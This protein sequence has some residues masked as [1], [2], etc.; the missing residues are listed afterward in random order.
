MDYSSLKEWAS[1]R[2]LEIL[3][4]LI[5]TKTKAQ[6]AKN[7]KLSEA[8]V[9]SCIRRVQAK[10]AK[11][12]YSPEHD[13]THTAPDTHIVKGVSSYYDDKGNLSRQWV[14]TDLKKGAELEAIKAFAQGLA[15]DLTN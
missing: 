8:T 3:E 7:L 10:A 13:M 12:G 1:P 6:A 5:L 4:A 9:Y 14:K 15:E 2:Q 11:Q